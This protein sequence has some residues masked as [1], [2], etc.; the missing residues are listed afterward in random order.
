MSQDT[1]DAFLKAQPIIG[2]WVTFTGGSA[3]LTDIHSGFQ[4]NMVIAIRTK[5]DEL[6]VG[7]T[8]HP[9]THLLLQLQTTG[10]RPWIRWVDIRDYRLITPNERKVYDNVI[11]QDYIKES[12]A[13]SD[14]YQKAK[15]QSC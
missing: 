11:L 7:Y 14:E 10:I 15:A 13:A 6:T 8:G 3:I 12:L 4:C 1:L 9:E 2:D 5:H